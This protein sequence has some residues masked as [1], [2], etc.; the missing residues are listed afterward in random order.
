MMARSREGAFDI[1]EDVGTRRIPGSTTYDASGQ[2]YTVTGGGENLWGATDEFHFAALKV[3]GDF[4]LTAEGEFKGTGINAHRKWGIMFRQ[5]LDG[6]SMYADAAIHG[7]G[8]TSLQYRE[9]N[10]AETRE[11]KAAMSSPDVVQLERAGKSVIMRAAK[12]GEALVETGRIAMDFSTEILAGLFV[13]SHEISVAETAVFRN[14]RFDVPAAERVG[15]REES[16]AQQAGAA[17]RGNGPSQDRLLER[18]TLRG[19]QLVARRQVSAVQPGR[20][21]L[22]VPLRH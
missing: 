1:V 5:G 14:V 16:V 8:L 3:S 12:R 13:C 6:S 4:M 9:Q 20:Q 11:V 15:R 10:G 17:G 22:Q 18:R 21:D 19:A 7:D 2:S